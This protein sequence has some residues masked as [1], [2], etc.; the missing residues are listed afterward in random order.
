MKLLI[1][2]LGCLLF[3]LGHAQLPVSVMEQFNANTN[4]WWTG[5]DAETS[6]Q[7]I[8]GKYVIQIAQPNSGRYVTIVPKS[9]L[10]KDFS[11]EASF[12]QKSGSTNNGFGLVW[13]SDG[14]GKQCE[15]IIASDGHFTIKNAEGGVLLTPLSNKTKKLTLSR[16]NA[17]VV[18]NV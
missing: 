17:S 13:G 14:A 7:I 9:D 10:A 11:V 1:T 18:G 6:L 16:E 8:N 5:T 4:G 2:A 3:S 15:F 12:I